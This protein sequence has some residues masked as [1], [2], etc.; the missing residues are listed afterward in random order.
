MDS[1]SGAGMTHE[2]NATSPHVI[3]S[4]VKMTFLEGGFNFVDIYG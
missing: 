2:K 3:N 1:G 4:V